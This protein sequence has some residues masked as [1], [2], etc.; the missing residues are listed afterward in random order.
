MDLMSRRI[1]A[2]NNQTI[3]EKVIKNLKA[4]PAVRDDAPLE[5]KQW[6]D[7]VKIIYDELFFSLMID[8]YRL[9]I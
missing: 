9:Y 4:F 7:Y 2:A 5:T 1:V 6:R 8:T 3:A